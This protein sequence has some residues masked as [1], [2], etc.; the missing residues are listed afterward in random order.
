MS[1]Y[2]NP[3]APF[4]ATINAG[5]TGLTGTLG[6]RILDG[7]GA[8]TT[9]RTTAGILELIPG[10]G[11][12]TANLTAPTTA[13]EYVVFWDTGTVTPTTSGG[14]DLTVTYDLPSTPA[15]SPDAP[16][17]T[18]TEFRARFTD[19]SGQTDSAIN[20]YRAVAER[21]YEDEIG[22]ALVPRT[23]TGTF[24]PD[25][26]WLRLA[27]NYVRSVTAASSS[28]GALTL[29]DLRYQGAYAYFT[30]WGSLPVTVTYT[31]GLDAPSAVDKHA[32]MTLTRYYL[33]GSNSVVDDRATG[34]AMED[35]GIV[36]ISIWP[37]EVNRAVQLRRVPSIA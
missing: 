27:H 13:G 25:G 30:G 34:L 4:E 6:V 9:P 15:G 37:R 1:I 3:A 33:V 31:H 2:A 18:P 35:G 19:L 10:S 24:H 21:A 32:V 26:D 11:V 7:D 29:S 8:T 17:F 23:A 22:Y 14:E 36:N 5:Q 16:Y 20:S 28:T 12:Y